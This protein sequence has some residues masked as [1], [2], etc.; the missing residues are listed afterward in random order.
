MQDDRGGRMRFVPP[1]GWFDRPA[2]R[3]ESDG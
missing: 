1:L 2:R 3:D